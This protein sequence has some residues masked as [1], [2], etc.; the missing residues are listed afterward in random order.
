[1]L[2]F[3]AIKKLQIMLKQHDINNYGVTLLCEVYMD[4]NYCKIL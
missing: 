1:M 4:G 2:M 3:L